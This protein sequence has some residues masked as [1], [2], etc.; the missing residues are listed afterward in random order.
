MKVALT[1]A[2]SDSGGGAGIQ[3]DLKTFAA[4]RVYGTCAITSV[5]AQNTIGVSAIHDLPPDFVGSQID[6]IFG[7]FQVNACKSGMLSNRE[8]ISVVVEKLENQSIENYVLDPVMVA[9]SGDRLL[10]KD[11]V[12][13]LRD[14]LIPLCRVLTPNREEA[15]IL[16]GMTIQSVEDMESAARKIQNLGC[17]SVVI[18]GG[19]EKDEIIDV[20]YDGT[21]HHLK[22]PYIHSQNTHGTGCTFSSAIAAELAKDVSPLQAVSTAKE[23][24]TTAITFSDPLGHGHGPQNHFA[25]LYRESEKFDIITQLTKAVNLLKESKCAALI[26]EV[27]SNLVMALPQARDVSEVAGFPGRIIKMKNTITAV[28]CPAFG[29]SSH[30]ARVV[31][32]A[33]NHDPSIR[34]AMNIRYGK[35]ILK[36]ADMRGL[37][38]GSFSREDEPPEIKAREGSTLDWGTDR[39][40]TGTGRVPDIIFDKGGISREAMVRVL[41]KTPADVTVK[42]LSI[43]RSLTY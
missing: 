21:V 28:G 18:K 23:F 26:P 8:I 4:L 36:A 34:S 37:E 35:D 19:R 2:G 20:F 42:V 3:A 38:T 1:I 14:E 16:S 30:M 32:A 11:A 29:A 17:E 9:T 6:T 33:M 22:A 25:Q 24:I 43:L 15:S 41:G 31:L 12:S 7:D 10:K 39:A 40:I 27:Q 13:A 5:T